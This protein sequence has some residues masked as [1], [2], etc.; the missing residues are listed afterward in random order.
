[1]NIY[2]DVQ[3]IMLAFNVSSRDNSQPSTCFQT[4]LVCTMAIDFE[5]SQTNL[6]HRLLRLL[7]PEAPPTIHSVLPFKLRGKTSVI[8]RFS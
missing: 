5:L 8:S 7:M 1:M 3:A 2:D 6:S 4:V